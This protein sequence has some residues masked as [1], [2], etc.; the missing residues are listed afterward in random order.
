MEVLKGLL[1]LHTFLTF[2]TFLTSLT[3][4]CYTPL[5]L[6]F[7]FFSYGSPQQED[8]RTS[9]FHVH[10]DEVG[11]LHPPL[12]CGSFRSRWCV[13]DT[14]F[15]EFRGCSDVAIWYDEWLSRTHC[16]R[17]LRPW[18]GEELALLYVWILHEIVD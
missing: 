10:T 15:D 17:P 18:M 16:F 4:L 9:A 2:N 1:F 12:R 6:L 14:C 13:S 7:P 8:G 5:H 3:S 11:R